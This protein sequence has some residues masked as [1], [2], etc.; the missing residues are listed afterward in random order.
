MIGPRTSSAPEPRAAW[1][2]APG[3]VIGLRVVPTGFAHPL[4]NGKTVTLGSDPDRDVWLEDASVSRSHCHF[5]WRMNRRGEPELW[6][7]DDDSYN[8]TFI[9]G[10][11]T[12][13][14]RIEDGTLIHVGLTRLVAFSAASQR[15]RTR[16]ELLVGQ[17]L[18]FCAAVDRALAA[19]TEKAPGLVIRGERG[20]GRTTVA[21]AIH[22]IQGQPTAPLFEIR[23][24]N[25][26]RKRGPTDATWHKRPQLL[27]RARGGLVYIHELN[28]QSP[29]AQGRIFLPVL[30][31]AHAGELRFVVSASAPCIDGLFPADLPVV[32]LPPLRERG[33]DLWV[34]VDHFLAR[35]LGRHRSRAVLPQPILD[36]LR[37]YAW[38]GNVAELAK[39]I[40]RLAAV[41]QNDGSVFRA[42]RALGL[43]HS[44]LHEWFA[45]RSIPLNRLTADER[46]L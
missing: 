3:P 21:R 38:P 35:H 33:P 46:E 41:L 24:L 8:G 42:A 26:E 22:E 25:D 19:M 39:T 14:A 17:D 31:L 9:N 29:Q 36:A 20:T 27:A 13:S 28:V 32:T 37:A 45:F 2:P 10:V 16:D 18:H 5:T 6:L 34:L 30:D 12:G 4:P 40:E 11:R 23:C 44:T 1:A 43:S 15:R 7:V